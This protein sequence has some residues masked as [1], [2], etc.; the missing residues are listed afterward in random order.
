MVSISTNAVFNIKQVLNKE[1]KPK[2]TESILI[3]N[4]KLG[5]KYQKL[6]I[7]K[8]FLDLCVRRKVCPP[9]IL[10]LAKRV[11]GQETSERNEKARDVDEE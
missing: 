11:G 3:S 2:W 8:D 5:L 10:A 9:E 7:Q 6:V 4:I 1:L